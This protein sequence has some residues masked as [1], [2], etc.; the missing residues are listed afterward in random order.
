[1][2]ADMV[3]ERELKLLNHRRETEP[4]GLVLSFWDLKTHPLVTHFLQQSHT[5]SNK[6]TPLN[7][8]TPYGPSSQI[9]GLIATTII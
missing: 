2:Q 6:A 5:Y 7:S 9:D 1:M 4:F 3:L 8:A